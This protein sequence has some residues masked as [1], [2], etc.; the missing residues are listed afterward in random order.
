MWP[1]FMEPST[2]P[3]AK[4]SEVVRSR[5]WSNGMPRRGAVLAAG[6]GGVE[7]DSRGASLTGAELGGIVA[8]ARKEVVVEIGRDSRVQ[9]AVKMRR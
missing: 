2:K 6:R 7:R 4:D 9:V 3:E 8:M 5:R 1:A